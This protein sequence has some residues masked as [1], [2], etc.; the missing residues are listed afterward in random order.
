MPAE[1]FFCS[2]E[3]GIRHFGRNEFFA[4][5]EVWEDQWHLEKGDSRKFLHGLIQMAAGF[6]KI[7]VEENPRGLHK[8]LMKATR[9][10]DHFVPHRFGVD[11]ESLIAE[12]PLWDERALRVMSGELDSI[13]ESFPKIERV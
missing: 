8:S 10:L 13:E 4:A 1:G 2:L 12:I 3:A 5:H 6:H 9:N 11:V 7:H